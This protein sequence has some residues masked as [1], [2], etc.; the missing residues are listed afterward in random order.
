MI[1]SIAA[2]Y[3]VNPVVQ[4]Q[5]FLVAKRLFHH[6][7]CSLL[8][9]GNWEDFHVFRYLLWNRVHIFPFLLATFRLLFLYSMKLMLH[10]MASYI[11]AQRGNLHIIVISLKDTFY[12]HA[13]C[14]L[15]VCPS[16]PLSSGKR[17]R[18]KTEYLKL[19]VY[20]RL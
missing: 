4:C 3:L 13:K 1:C 2:L 14:L 19:D 11:L 17:L 20:H 9:E 16:D 7:L 15:G 10:W 5:A 8:W 12:K 18:S 6:W